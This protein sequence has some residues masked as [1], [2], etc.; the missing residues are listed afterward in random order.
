MQNEINSRQAMEYLVDLGKEDN[1]NRI[2]QVQISG[3]GGPAVPVMVV[4]TKQ[5]VV[6]LST[7]VPKNPDRIRAVVKINS[8]ASFAAYVAERKT[9]HTRIFANVLTAPYTFTAIMDYHEVGGQVPAWCAHEAILTL[10]ESREWKTWASKNDTAMRQEEFA[11]F[12]EQNVADIVSPD[13]ATM[14]ELALS[15]EASQGV[16]FR[17]KL[18]LQNGDIG[19][20]CDQ[21]T[22]MKAGRDGQIRIPGEITLRLAPFR[23]MPAMEVKARFRTVL[24]PPN[25]S[26]GYQLIRAEAML[27]DVVAKA[28]DQIATETGVTIYSGSLTQTK[29]V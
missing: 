1:R 15:L 14:L 8:V 23:G 17:N 24:R 11:L 27:D 20:V 19:L 18:N 26:L 10:T 25:I 5:K 9:A 6:D 29:V 21:Q 13:G 7:F 12:V 22:N 2:H 28:A 4:G 16:E 3:R